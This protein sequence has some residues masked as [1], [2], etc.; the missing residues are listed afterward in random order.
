MTLIVKVAPDDSHQPVAELL[1]KIFVDMECKHYPHV[2]STDNAGKDQ[3]TMSDTMFEIR[4]Q[5]IQ[6]GLSDPHTTGVTM[7]V[8]DIWHARE[9]VARALN[10]GHADYYPALAELKIIFARYALIR[11]VESMHP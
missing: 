2:I 8:Q 1:Q 3:H 7:V 4:K 11:F 10:R 5:R 6:K 9:R